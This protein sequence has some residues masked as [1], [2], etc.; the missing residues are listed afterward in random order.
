MKMFLV[1]EFTFHIIFKT[2]VYKSKHVQEENKFL[3]TKPD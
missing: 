2:W 3:S 1:T